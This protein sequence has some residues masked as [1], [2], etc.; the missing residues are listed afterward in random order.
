MSREER[1]AGVQGWR[2]LGQGEGEGGARSFTSV[3]E[4]ILLGNPQQV[5]VIP[6]MRNPLC[7]V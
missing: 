3:K 1:N 6:S 7:S 4:E 2:V 5:D